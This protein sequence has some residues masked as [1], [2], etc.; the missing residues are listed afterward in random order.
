[1]NKYIHFI[2]VESAE[3]RIAYAL[4]ADI[5]FLC[6]M[7][8]FISDWFVRAWSV[9]MVSISLSL[10]SCSATCLCRKFSFLWLSRFII[11]MRLFVRD[12]EAARW[13]SL[14]FVFCSRRFLFLL[15]SLRHCCAVRTVCGT[16]YVCCRSHVLYN[17]G[18]MF[19]LRPLLCV[20][21]RLSQN[22]R[23]VAIIHS[24]SFLLGRHHSMESIYFV[25]CDKRISVNGRILLSMHSAFVWPDAVSLN[26]QMVLLIRKFWSTSTFLFDATFRRAASTQAALASSLMPTFA[27]V[28]FYMQRNA[29]NSLLICATKKKNSN[30]RALLRY[31]WTNENCLNVHCF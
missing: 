9:W 31:V 20:R 10:F 8:Y 25:V 30:M 14:S 2:R 18:G 26:W 11:N 3:C 1:M 24:D 5:Y 29:N 12:F 27:I 6:N 17:T 21:C 23:H 7:C 13:F 22:H 16:E 15:H 19:T 28:Y 4:V